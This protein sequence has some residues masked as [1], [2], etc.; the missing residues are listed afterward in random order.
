MTTIREGGGAEDDKTCGFDPQSEML[1]PYVCKLAVHR[2]RG[3]M[4][5]MVDDA[6]GG[7]KADSPATER[8]RE[9]QS[10]KIDGALR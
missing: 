3:Q 10:G 1:L 8:S 6:Q 2:E 5:C 9:T 7:L 4:G